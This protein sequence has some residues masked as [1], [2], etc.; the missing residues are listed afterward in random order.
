MQGETDGGTIPCS[1]SNGNVAIEMTAKA[2]IRSAGRRRIDARAAGDYDD[3]THVTLAKVRE[4][5]SGRG[6]LE[7][8]LPATR[9]DE[10][11]RGRVQKKAVVRG[12]LAWFWAYY[13]LLGSDPFVTNG[14]V[15]RL[16]L[17][18]GIRVEQEASPWRSARLASI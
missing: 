3:G 18:G 4:S 2:V 1:A 16:D 17:S 14:M 13:R 8:A 5:V 11:Q 9:N 12:A 15:R 6:R 7:E 10:R